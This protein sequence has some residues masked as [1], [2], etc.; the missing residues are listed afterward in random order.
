[1]KRVAGYLAVTTA[2]MVLAGA[3]AAQAIPEDLYTAELLPGWNT[4]EGTR[5][6]ALHLT[7][8]E[9]WKTYWRAPGE[10]GIPPI[11]DWSGSRN[12]ASVTYHWPAPEVFELSGYTTFG[13]HGELVLPIEIRPQDPGQPILASAEVELGICEEICVPVAFRIAGELSK[14]G[15]DKRIARALDAGPVPAKTAGLTGFQCAVEPIR[16]GLR[17]TATL[18]MPPLGGEEIAVLEAG[19]GDIWVS[20]AET[21]REGGRLVSVA[22]LIPPNARPFALDRSSVVVT[23][24]SPGRAVQQIGCTG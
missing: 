19:A 8:K 1:M 10:A 4:P 12:V 14:G 17:L 11:F 22:D 15:P 2:C 23:V 16:D 6:A 21:R 7:L 3:A 5:M 24:L 13:F 18:T 9:G 20:P